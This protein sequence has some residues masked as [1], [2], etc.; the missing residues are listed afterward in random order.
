VAKLNPKQERF[1][2]EYLVDLNAKQAAIRAGYSERTAE[3][4]G[5]RLLSN[6]KV[7]EAIQRGKAKREHRLEVTQDRVVLELARIAFADVRQYGDWGVPDVDD[8]GRADEP[9]QRSGLKPSTELSDDQTAAVQEVTWLDRADGSVQTKLKLHDKIGALTLLGKHLGMFVD[10]TKLE[11][12]V[13]YSI[14]MPPDFPEVPPAHAVGEASDAPP[15]TSASDDAHAGE[16]ANAG[17]D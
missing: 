7:A 1:V 4:Q 17:H 11:G 10:R 9:G 14:I 15:G 2:A 12:E 8:S 5:S 3:S 13:T 16:A 6:A